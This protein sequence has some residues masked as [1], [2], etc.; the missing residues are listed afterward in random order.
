MVELLAGGDA[1]RAVVMGGGRWSCENECHAPI[2][3]YK[4]NANLSAKN[5]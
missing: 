1:G 2:L 5:I 4:G 3:V